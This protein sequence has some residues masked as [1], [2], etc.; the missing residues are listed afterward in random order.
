MRRLLMRVLERAME[1]KQIAVILARDPS[2]SA[3]AARRGPRGDRMRRAN[4][5]ASPRGLY[6]PDRRGT[7][8]G[9]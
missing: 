8:R 3:N 5:A 2:G 9:R 6:Y 4:R 7:V 1:D